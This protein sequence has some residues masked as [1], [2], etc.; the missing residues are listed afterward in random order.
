MTGATFA[1][2]ATDT[3]GVQGYECQ[4][5]GG[6]YSAC[7]SS[8]NY[9]GLSVAS[10]TFNVR[11]TDVAGNTSASQNYTWTIQSNSAPDA[12]DDLANMNEG[13]GTVE[14]SVLTNDTDA[15]TTDTLSV[16]GKTDGTRGTVIITSGGTKVTCDPRDTS[17]VS[18]HSLP[19]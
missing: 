14:V 16:T 12:I 10:H 15:D 11:A 6:G 2:S 4:I 3:N 9:T 17:V 13:T 1:F 5:D 7:T 18:T 8:K 19:H